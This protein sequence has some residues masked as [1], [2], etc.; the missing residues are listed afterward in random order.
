MVWM[1]ARID[2]ELDRLGTECLNSRNDFVRQPSSPGVHYEYAFV[3]RL[4]GDIPAVTHKHV[5]IALSGQD[6]D[7]A[8]V[9]VRVHGST[10]LRCTGGRDGQDLCG[11]FGINLFEFVCKFGVYRCRTAQHC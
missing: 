9:R 11:R 3:T 2:N 7:L 5:Y 4:N 10:H 1:K 8:V 6:M